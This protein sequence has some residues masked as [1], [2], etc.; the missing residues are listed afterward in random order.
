ML[1]TMKETHRVLRVGVSNADME[2]LGDPLGSSARNWLSLSLAPQL[3][4]REGRQGRRK[5]GRE[6]E[7]K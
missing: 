7:R 5:E 6:G 4:Y 1:S 2:A 3:Q